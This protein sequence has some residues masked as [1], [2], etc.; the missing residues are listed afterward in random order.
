MLRQSALLT[1]RCISLIAAGL[2][3][4]SLA[5]AQS[6]EPLH[7]LPTDLKFDAKKVALGFKLFRDPRFAKD[8]SVSCITCHSFQHGGADPRQVPV[9]AGGTKH[10]FNSP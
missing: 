9:G 4:T 6:D 7:P 3:A 5:V 8:N 1:L 10:I 2:M